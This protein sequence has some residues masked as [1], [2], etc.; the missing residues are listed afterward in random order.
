[1]SYEEIS[2]GR[3]QARKDYRCEWCNETIAKGDR[4]FYRVYKFEGDFN[5]G[6]MHLECMLAMDKAPKDELEGGWTPGDYPRGNS[7]VAYYD[8]ARPAEEEKP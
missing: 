7:S 3:P 1:M 8:P 6:R 5:S 4:H 2:T